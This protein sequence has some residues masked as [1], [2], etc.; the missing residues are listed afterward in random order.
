MV[1]QIEVLNRS[2]I[3]SNFN[4]EQSSLDNY[5]Q[6]QASQ[7]V[8]RR[9][10]AVFVLVD[11]PEMDVLAYYTLSAFTVDIAQLD[12]ASA[13][14]LPNYPYIPATLLGRLAVDRR[15]QG[16]KFGRL[17]LLDALK[18]AIDSSLQVASIA[19][20]VEALDERAATFYKKYGFQSSK[21]DPSKLYLLMRSIASMNL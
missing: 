14:R 5:I 10:S 17:M 1:L 15:F 12:E 21:Q 2:H 16:K 4:C 6:T 13:K 3:R 11:E 8:K 9:I 7:D 20:V 18:R 19:V